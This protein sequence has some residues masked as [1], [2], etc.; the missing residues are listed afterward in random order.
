MMFVLLITLI[1][2][3]L[4]AFANGANDNSKGVATLIGSGLFST[5]KAI[6]YAAATTF[7][8]SIAA[9]FL[10]TTLV[11]RF[12]GK[13]IVD[14][15]IVSSG[16]FAA[17]VG[18]AASLTVLIATRLAM[19][20]STT[21]AMVGAI[22]GIGLSANALNWS[23]AMTVFFLPLLISPL[24]AVVFAIAAYLFFRFSRRKL[25]VTR[26]TCVCI[27]EEN[28]PVA[29]TA[30]GSLS[31]IST[32]IKIDIDDESVCTE[33]YAG[34][35]AGVNAQKVLDYS[36]IFTA[37]ALSFARGLND[38]PKIAA[39]L[40]VA[41][42]LTTIHP[43]LALIAVGIFIAIG[44][45]LMVRRVANTMSHQITEMNDG[46]A[47]TA[48]LVTALLVIVASRFG[49]PVSTTHVS[50]G[51]LFGIGAVNCK[52]HW[53]MVGKI[54]VAWVTTLPVAGIIGFF[55]WKIFIL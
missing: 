3:L 8:G 43:S 20:I 54:V 12:G 44:G 45:V 48:N 42:G 24:L 6:I 55:A 22:V 28:H 25:G 18:L 13:G 41:G 14:A 35:I 29:C 19:P 4:L 33:R 10:A 30:D 7:L 51:S 38:T 31:V 5:K 15:A 47:F 50:C 53:G 40:V 27:G 23:A 9:I 16:A 32:G 36:H 11:D 1:F 52:G 37:G 39:V 21:H 49:L 46:Q 17:S 2:A 34:S 26:Q